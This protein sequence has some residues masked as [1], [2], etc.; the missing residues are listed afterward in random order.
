MNR[1]LFPVLAATSV[2]A[3]AALAQLPQPQ[4]LLRAAPRASWTTVSTTGLPSQRRDNP[5]AASADRIYVFGGRDGNANSTTH[6]ALYEFD[7]SA[8]TVLNPDTSA[9]GFPAPRGG[10]AVAWNFATNRLMVFGGDTGTGPVGGPAVTQTLLG[11]TWEWDPGT[12]TWTDVTLPGGPSPRRNASMTWDPATGGMVLF[13]GDVSL[14]PTSPVAETWVFV[15]GTWLPFA[16]ANVPPARH[17]HSLVTRGAPYGDV[18]LC[19]G[20]DDSLTTT[21]DRLRHL[22]V[23]TWNGADWTKI[24][25]YDFV[26]QTGT[27]PASAAAAQAVYDPLRQRV[28][29]QGG[30]GISVG[31]FTSSAATATPTNTTFVYGWFNAGTG[32]WEQY[33]GSPTNWTSEFDCTTNQWVLYSRKN[34]VPA[35][36]TWNENDPV[37]GRLSRYFAAFL[38]TTGKVYKISGQPNGGTTGVAEYQATPVAS[39]TATAPTCTGPGG[40]LLSLSADAAPWLGGS[41]SLT[42][43][44]L[45]AGTLNLGLLNFSTISIPLAAIDPLHGLPGCDLLVPIDGNEMTFF[46]FPTG[47]AGSFGLGLPLA[48]QFAGI[49][50]HLQSIQV[51]FNGALQLQ[52]YSS[53]NR[54]TA[55]LGMP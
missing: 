27:H 39:T 32:Q 3:P 30:Q 21:T 14:S 51:E 9:A 26:T 23:W 1:H 42:A 35:L 46:F 36:A 7:G 6:N 24:S 29:L 34:T 17:N 15:A 40:G 13:G 22:D 8:F 50:L 20:V 4:T 16:P 43:T 11:D 52:S 45:A 48:P 5:G 19:G 33:N 10:A 44:G 41:L 18:L 38:P 53:T 47:G 25:D 2:L 49:Q 28:V 54:V 55:T 12:N 37:I 31:T